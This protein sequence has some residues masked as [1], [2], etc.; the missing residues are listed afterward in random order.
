MESTLTAPP[1][2]SACPRDQWVHDQARSNCQCCGKGFKFYRRRH[3]CRVCGDLV[4]SKCSRTVYLI[5]TTSNIGRACVDCASPSLLRASLELLGDAPTS[6]DIRPTCPVYR[7]SLVPRPWYDVDA[8][9]CW[10][11]ECTV[12]IEKFADSSGDIVELSCHHVFHHAC[13]LPWLESHDECPVCRYGLPRDMSAFY[14][15]ISF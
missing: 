4:C 7:S 9:S 12:C 2:R 8:S 3:H 15:F 13:I 6:V 14:R 1:V 10:N 11:D 5:N